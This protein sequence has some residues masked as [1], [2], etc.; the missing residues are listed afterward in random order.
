MLL[1]AL[2]VAF[3][4][5]RVRNFRE[6]IRSRRNGRLVIWRL[7]GGGEFGVQA[8][9]SDML[10]VRETILWNSY[11]LDRHRTQCGFFI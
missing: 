5:G 10:A 7:R 11:V 8:G 3:L 2:D 6:V 9:S 4:I 1:R